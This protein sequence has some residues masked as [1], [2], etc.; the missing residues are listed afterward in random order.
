MNARWANALLIV[1]CAGSLTASGV[2]ILQVKCLSTQLQQVEAA[3]QEAGGSRDFHSATVSGYPGKETTGDSVELNREIAAL[4]EAIENMNSTG[5]AT[6]HREPEIDHLQQHQRELQQQRAARTISNVVATGYWTQADAQTF[7]EQT[8]GLPPE[9][10][11]KV[12]EPVIRG[13]KDGT[14]QMPEDLLAPF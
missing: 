4:R 7:R 11:Q 10:V 6:G 2:L 14:L 9:A 13:L 5:Q 3:L 1:V 12:A 8:R